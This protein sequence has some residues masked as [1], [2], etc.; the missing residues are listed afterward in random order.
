MAASRLLVPR[1]RALMMGRF[2]AVIC[3]A[4]PV[5]SWADRWWKSRRADALP[6]FIAQI[7]AAMASSRLVSA[8]AAWLPQN[9]LLQR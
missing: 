9:D 6:K 7:Q 1:S 8:A 4:A 3:A 5:A 2:V